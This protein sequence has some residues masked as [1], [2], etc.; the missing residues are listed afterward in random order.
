MIRPVSK[1]TITCSARLSAA[2]ST[3]LTEFER[4]GG[5]QW[6]SS[7]L[8]FATKQAK[9]ALLRVQRGLCCEN[10]NGGFCK[11][12]VAQGME[13]KDVAFFCFITNHSHSFSTTKGKIVKVYRI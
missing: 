5:K 11:P 13:G 10:N 4:A 6:M 8:R 2:V 9:D 12:A 3:M 1:S 7:E